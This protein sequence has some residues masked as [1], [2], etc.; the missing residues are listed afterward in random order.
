M[1]PIEPSSK[2][3]FTRTDIFASLIFAVLSF[4]ICI[5]VVLLII[6]QPGYTV[7]FFL[8]ILPGS[9]LAILIC[10][11]CYQRHHRLEKK[12]LETEKEEI[13][14]RHSKRLIDT[15]AC[16]NRGFNNILTVIS[17]MMGNSKNSEDIKNYI[18]NI[19]GELHLLFLLLCG[20][21]PVI[22]SLILSHAIIAKEKDIT[23][24]INSN[25][26]LKNFTSKLDLLELIIDRCLGLI[27]EN[28]ITAK[29]SER[30]IHVDITETEKE[31]IFYFCNSEEAIKTFKSY[32]LLTFKKSVFLE[33][34]RFRRF[35]REGAEKFKP[36]AR[37][38][39]KLGAIY[40]L[41]TYGGFAAELSIWIKK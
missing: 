22:G 17:L 34:Q 3:N 10:F 35:R 39:A 4:L 19:S 12:V 9:A 15:T 5:P 23:I 6:P 31:F 37:L 2:R 40:E 27:V 7:R 11:F 33:F 24:L 41:R 18:L 13:Q 1:K 16:L 14:F 30:I 28:E 32:K 8:T 21:N 38:I 29:S 26:T 25:T 20:V 36:V